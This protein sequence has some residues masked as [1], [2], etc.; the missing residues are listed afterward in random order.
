LA[1]EGVVSL[2]ISGVNNERRRMKDLWKIKIDDD[3]K[4]KKNK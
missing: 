1:L 3:G 4:R 2:M